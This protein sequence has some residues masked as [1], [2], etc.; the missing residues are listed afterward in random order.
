MS[1]AL[2][3]RGAVDQ[4][5]TGNPQI[6]FFKTVYRRYTPFSLYVLPISGQNEYN[7]TPANWTNPTME[8]NI[9]MSLGDLLCNTWVQLELS[10]SCSKPLSS[11]SYIN[12]TNN[13]GSAIVEEYKLMIGNQVLDKQDSRYLDIYN[14]L[15]QNDYIENTLLNKAP[16]HP[17]SLMNSGTNSTLNNTKLELNV[18]LK[19]W[20]CRNSG[21]SIPLICL[22]NDNL[23]ISITLRNLINCINC[24][25]D[26][27]K[28]TTENDISLKGTAQIFGKFIKLGKDERIRFINSTHEYLIEQV[29]NG[30]S[31]ISKEFTKSPVNLNTINGPV[32][33]LMWFFQYKNNM[34]TSNELTEIDPHFT[35]CYQNYFNY[36]CNNPLTL[37][38]HGSGPNSASNTVV[39]LL[40]QQNYPFINK[41]Q[42]IANGTDLTNNNLNPSYFNT[43]E[44]YRCGYNMPSKFI[45][46]YS[47]ALNPKE[48]QPSGT[49]NF[50]QLSN[51]TYI[52]WEYGTNNKSSP[53]FAK[54]SPKT[55]NPGGA[56]DV[57]AYVYWINY[58]ILRIASGQAGLAY[59]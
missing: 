42:I 28:S 30:G 8:N 38:T 16:N 53:H 29:C 46:I 18:D 47:F 2:V 4:Y 7:G 21:L 5:L 1:I 57:T 35:A 11:A 49:L 24:T 27:I 51:N 31:C 23:K 58:N 20:F 26:S 12:W 34:K 32:K 50:S 3:A 44:P 36:N 59:T 41:T 17:S 39:T 19:F 14:E 37:G 48:H 13:T 55:P 56:N 33:Q 15:H 54:E 22:N 43:F 25:E 9:N 52:K 40:N 10:G 45:Y 6:S